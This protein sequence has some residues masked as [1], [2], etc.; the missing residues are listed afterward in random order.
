M[1]RPRPVNP[2]PPRKSGPPRWL[3][4]VVV[5]LVTLSLIATMAPSVGTV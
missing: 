4:I 5:A 3:L 1:S 2:D